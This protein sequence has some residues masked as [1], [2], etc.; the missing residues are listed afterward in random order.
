MG[1]KVLNPGLL[2]TVQDTGRFGYQKIGISPS[3][4]L[5][6]TALK[7]ANI[8]V[9]NPVGE[10]GLE[11]TMLGATLEF[12]EKNYIAATGGDFQPMLN[13]QPM[14]LY[15]AVCVTAGST[16]SFGAAK[17]GCRTYLAF[18][19]GLDVPDVMGSKSTNLKCG[20]GGYQGRRLLSGDE[21]PFVSP[22][23]E[24]RFPMLR[25][26]KVPDDPEEIVTLRVIPGPQDDAFTEQGLSTFFG[27]IYEVTNKCDRMGCTLE[28]PAV[29][30]KSK[31]D[32]I[33]DGIPLGAVQIPSSGKPIVMLA[34]RQ[35]TGGYTKIGTV[36]STDLPQFVQ[37]KVGQK[38][39]FAPITMKEAQRLACK[40]QKRLR[41]LD[42]YLNH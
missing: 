25:K 10:A 20:F 41:K 4:A 19:G 12:T 3:G 23:M 5:D 31:A 17:T 27:G 29:E 16:L 6:Q 24:L 21:I 32:I 34:D 18:A 15:T 26:L 37:R 35:T 30:Y 13:G 8:L 9:G 36:I 33:S 22:A 40:E 39:R 28:G 1:I 14:P 7:T 2:T 11:M 38:V 42:R